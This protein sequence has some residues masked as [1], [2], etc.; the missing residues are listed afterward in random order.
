M[1]SLAI[2]VI[3]S[4][5]SAMV[6][7]QRTA[8]SNQPH[9]GPVRID[10]DGTLHTAGLIAIPPS[11]FWSPEFKQAYRNNIGTALAIKGGELLQAPSANASKS[12]WDKYDNE[13]DHYL[14]PYLAWDKEHYP[15]D[16]TDKKMA[17]VHVGII[18]PKTGLAA[19]NRHRILINLHGG[20]FSE[21]RGLVTGELESIPI[22]SIGGLEVVTV[23]YR[24]APYF[25][26]PA[27]TEDVEAVYQELLKRYKPESIG[28][29]GTSAGGVL[30]AQV[31]VAFHKKG[32]PRP[33]AV[34]IFWAGPG[35]FWSPLFSKQ[36]D[37]TAW[38][39]A[40]YP[41]ERI[42]GKKTSTAQKSPADYM[43][44]A[45]ANDPMANPF[46]S[47]EALGNFPSTLF[48]TGTRAFDMSPVIVAHARLLKLG[49]DS[50]LYV[51]EGGW[52]AADLLAVNAPET[53]DMDTYRARWFKQHLAL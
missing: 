13:L 29:F 11:Q 34:G 36:G 33:G 12:V 14:L 37:S 40:L 6:L 50:S 10:T 27:A 51:I 5:V 7:S 9:L 25:K 45:D 41:T 22:A 28:I 31:L 44:G 48:T 26:F 3:V 15:V 18:T 16:I 46:S 24:E 8:A 32:L 47:D 30:A 19:E 2:A 38:I 23:D 35:P 39:R 1:L 42:S 49:V 52:H 53:R 43:A 4:G 21:G 20:G 17:G